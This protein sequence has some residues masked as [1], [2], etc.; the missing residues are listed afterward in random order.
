[1]VRLKK[2]NS[3]LNVCN[4]VPIFFDE[5]SLRIYAAWVLKNLTFV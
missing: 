2:K 3:L 5:T 1:M 4:V